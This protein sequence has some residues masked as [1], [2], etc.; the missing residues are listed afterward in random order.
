MAITTFQN[1]Q[2]RYLKNAGQLGTLQANWVDTVFPTALAVWNLIDSKFSAAEAMV[3]KG[4]FPTTLP[5]GVQVGWSYVIGVGSPSTVGGQTVETGDLCIANV[6]NPVITNA[7][8]WTIV[9]ANINGAVTKQ[10]GV[11]TATNQLALW[12]G[13]GNVISKW[14]GGTGLVKIDS[15]GVV[16]IATGA[17]VPSHSHTISATGTDVTFSG[18]TGT[19]ITNTKVT[20]IAGYLLPL[21]API[22]GNTIVFNGS[23]WTYATAGSSN[24]NSWYLATSSGDTG[25]AIINAGKAIFAQGA[26]MSVTRSTNTVTISHATMTTPANFTGTTPK[27]VLTGTFT[28]GHTSA[29]TVRD[30]TANDVSSVY[31]FKRDKKTGTTSNT[32][33]LTG[34]SPIESTLCVYLN[35]QL[36]EAISDNYTYTAGTKTIAINTSNWGTLETLDVIEATYFS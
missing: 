23:Q 5:A 19:N 20:G 4:V 12:S 29:L 25:E 15:N 18:S 9:Q 21:A 30:L 17:D 24:Y 34:A 28:N 27:V 36:L 8:H 2:Y 11:I 14:N 6:T 13:T 10:T 32:L 35:G 1:K 16:T 7:A 31:G 26:N 33:I 22:N 3:F